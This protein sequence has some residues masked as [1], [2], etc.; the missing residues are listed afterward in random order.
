MNRVAVLIALTLAACTANAAEWPYNEK[1]DAEAD[2]RHALKAAQTDHK[3]VLLVFGA[4]WCK[5]CR[6]LDRAM[7]GSSL[8]L[9]EGKFEVVKIDVGNFDKNLKLAE[10]YGNPIK[11]GIPAVVE[12]SADDQV[13]YSTKG[14]ELADARKMSDQGIYDFLA[15]KLGP[16]PAASSGGEHLIP[17]S[18]ARF[19]G[20]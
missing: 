6:D 18:R 14:G 12:L 20:W 11:L 15:A 10:H 16:A 19:W 9:I 8:P 13:I 7:H 17:M 1:A 3:K 4:N 5:D 2:V